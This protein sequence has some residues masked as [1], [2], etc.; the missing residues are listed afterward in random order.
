MMHG[1]AI[2]KSEFHF[3]R[4]A[5]SRSEL[6]KATSVKRQTLGVALHN[7]NFA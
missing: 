7:R 1:S 2:E 3:F 6:E 5:R 4:N